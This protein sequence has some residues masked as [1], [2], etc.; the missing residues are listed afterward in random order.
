MDEL[1]TEGLEEERRLAYVGIT[2]AR[3]HLTIS[4]AANRRIYNQYQSNIP[5]RFLGEI[6]EATLEHLDGGPYSRRATGPAMFQREVESILGNNSSYATSSA[7]AR[8]TT[9]AAS[10]PTNIPTSKLIKGARVFHQKFGNGVILSSE[11]DHLEIAFK[12]AGTKK[13]LAEY[14]ELAG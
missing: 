2:R 14:V 13:I 4:H 9:F 7:S 1:G 5:S 8:G 11:G 6:P 10:T 12:H 3:Y